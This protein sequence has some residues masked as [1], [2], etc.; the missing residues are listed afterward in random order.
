MYF[1]RAVYSLWSE[2]ESVVFKR[3]WSHFDH[4]E[5]ILCV[6]YLNEVC[7]EGRTPLI[8]AIESLNTPV[9]QLLVDQVSTE[10]CITYAVEEQF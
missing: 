9:V 3:A 2:L 5:P 4:L 6:R 10:S 1:S 7:E 8:M